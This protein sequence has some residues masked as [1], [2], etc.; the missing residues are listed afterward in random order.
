MVILYYE[1]DITNTQQIPKV[2]ISNISLL[3][4]MLNI[5]TRCMSECTNH[6]FHDSVY[7]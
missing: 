7:L 2:I 4:T 1:N 6:F 3:N 5:W